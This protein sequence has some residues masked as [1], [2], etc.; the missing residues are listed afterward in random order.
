[1]QLGAFHSAQ[2]ILRRAGVEADNKAVRALG[3]TILAAAAEKTAGG[4]VERPAFREAWQHFAGRPR[5]RRLLWAVGLGTAAFSMQDILLEPYGGEILH[6]PVGATTALTAMMAGGAL[7][8]F[9]LAA[10]ALGR[11][12]IAL[13]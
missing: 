4:N 8:A 13:R 11:S 10:R 9:G 3:M 1:M 12:Q 2:R 7:A 5:V 6:L